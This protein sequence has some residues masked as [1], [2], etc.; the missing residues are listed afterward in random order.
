MKKQSKR[1]PVKIKTAA[2]LQVALTIHQ[3]Q[4]DICT[5]KEFSDAF[6]EQ[7]ARISKG[8]FYKREGDL[9]VA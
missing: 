8:D 9:K 5:L 4:I 1:K 6:D 7:E 3:A 2:Y